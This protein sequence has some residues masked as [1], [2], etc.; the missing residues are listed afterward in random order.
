MTD[1]PNTTAK[2]S[3][4]RKKIPTV[5]FFLCMFSAVIFC[6]T[7]FC[8]GTPAV[9]PDV[10]HQHFHD[11]INGAFEHHD[12]FDANGT[13]QQ[14]HHPDGF[15]P[16]VQSTTPFDPSAVHHHNRYDGVVPTSPSTTPLNTRML[17]HHH[18]YWNEISFRQSSTND[19]GLTF[20]S[21]KGRVL[22]IG[23]TT[24]A[25]IYTPTAELDGNLNTV[26][27]GKLLIYMRSSSDSVLLKSTTG[28]ATDAYGFYWSNGKLFMVNTN[29][30]IFGPDSKVEAP[31]V[32]ISTLDL[33]TADFLK[34][35]FRAIKEINR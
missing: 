34:V 30:F 21:G 1:K 33:S 2:K 13:F 23:D 20:A 27:N 6:S 29:G 3:K 26:T 9:T 8:D 12:H 25:Y 10:P 31:S 14:H 15:V 4:L 11:H 17:H 7:A 22:T 32:V 35:A 19:S 5:L 24:Y 28:V 18:N 16:G